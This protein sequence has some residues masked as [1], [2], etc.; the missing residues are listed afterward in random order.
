M[1]CFE[2]L[3]HAPFDRDAILPELLTEKERLWLNSYHEFV[4]DS[5]IPY[6][7]PD[8]AEWLTRETQPI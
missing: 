1:L 6:L 3:T 5:L 7:D 4:R 2:T 8:E